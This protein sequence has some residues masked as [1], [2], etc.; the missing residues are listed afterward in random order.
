VPAGAIA[1]ERSE[2]VVLKG[3]ATKRM[4]SLRDQKAAQLLKAQQAKQA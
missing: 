4:A 1:L 3:A 2:Q